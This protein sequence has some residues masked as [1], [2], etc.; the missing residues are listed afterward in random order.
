MDFL[1]K[2]LFSLEYVPS[3]SL[4][5]SRAYVLFS[6]ISYMRVPTYSTLDCVSMTSIAFS[7]LMPLPD[8]VEL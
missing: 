5:N 2:E 1:K 7:V 3:V 8:F 6:L 4:K